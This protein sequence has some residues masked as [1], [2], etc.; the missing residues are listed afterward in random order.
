MGNAKFER[1]GKE[2]VSRWHGLD[3]APRKTDGNRW[4]VAGKIVKNVKLVCQAK[5]Y[6]SVIKSRKYCGRSLFTKYKCVCAY[7]FMCIYSFY[8][9]C[10]TEKLLEKL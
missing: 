10:I 7:F 8:V 3:R 4:N 1:N 6:Q 2:I 9:Q 5:Y